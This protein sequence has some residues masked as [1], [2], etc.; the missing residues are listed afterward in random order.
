MGSSGF[1]KYFYGNG[2]PVGPQ[3]YVYKMIR[4]ILFKYIRICTRY[5]DGSYGDVEP[6]K[7]NS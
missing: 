4:A 3:Q 2:D 1:I 6:A 7:K 5:V